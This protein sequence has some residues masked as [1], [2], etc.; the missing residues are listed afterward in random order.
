[1]VPGNDDAIADD[2]GGGTLAEAGADRHVAK[3]AA[4]EL[5]AIDRAG[6]EATGPEVG[7]HPLAVGAGGGGGVAVGLVGALVGHGR[8]GLPM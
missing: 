1:M 2:R 8:H 6:V 4:P 5:V 7:I 3:V